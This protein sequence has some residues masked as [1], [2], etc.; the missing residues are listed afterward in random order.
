MKNTTWGGMGGVMMGSRRRSGPC[1]TEVFS[2]LVPFRRGP[3]IS[4]SCRPRTVNPSPTPE[5]SRARL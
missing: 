1:W 5:A 2:S 3:W 4:R